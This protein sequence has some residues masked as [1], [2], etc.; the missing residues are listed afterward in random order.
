MVGIMTC[1]YCGCKTKIE[2]I[3][4]CTRAEISGEVSTAEMAVLTVFAI[5]PLFEATSVASGK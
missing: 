4:S 3:I 1:R 2:E 5:S